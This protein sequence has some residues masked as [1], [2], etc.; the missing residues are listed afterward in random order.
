MAQLFSTPLHLSI[1]LCSHDVSFPNHLYRQNLAQPQTPAGYEG[2]DPRGG[3]DGP[4]ENLALV[5]CTSPRKGC[6]R[7]K[8]GGSWPLQPL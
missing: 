6:C 7:R 8:E 5:P 4:K 1:V 3:R 2:A